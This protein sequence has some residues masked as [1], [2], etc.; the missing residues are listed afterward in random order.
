VIIDTSTIDPNTAIDV[1]RR[2]HD[3]GSEFL[4][5]PVSGG[6][7]G[8]AAATLAIMVGGERSAFEKS[9]A[10]LSKIGKNI[11]Y[12][13]VSGSGLRVK[14]FNQALV[15]V[16]FVGVSEAYLWAEKMGMK[17]EDLQR[18]I[19]MSWGDSPVFRHFAS[20]V[21]SGILKGGASMR[22]LKK[23]L[24]IILESAEKD[25]AQLTLVEIADSYLA[26]AVQQGYEEFDTSALY[27]I[28]DK[29]RTQRP[30]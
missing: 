13:G 20:V 12:L 4:D 6:P 27:T 3:R 16:Y 28:L 17:I 2:I 5:A 23:D 7:E 11:F 24:D 29:V 10:V 1:A 15:G 25:G 14:L 9:Q 30:K 8:A 21:S 26:K 19:S 22:N 18:I